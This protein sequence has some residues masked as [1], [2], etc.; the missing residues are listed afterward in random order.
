MIQEVA[1]GWSLGALS[2]LFIQQLWDSW[3]SYRKDLRLA[4]CECKGDEQ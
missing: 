2:M 4:R 3:D 1:F